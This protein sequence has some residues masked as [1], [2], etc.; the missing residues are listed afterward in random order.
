MVVRSRRSYAGKEGR[1][2]AG[3]DPEYCPD[4]ARFT[5]GDFWSA[6]GM[7]TIT[8]SSGYRLSII[9]HMKRRKEEKEDARYTDCRGYQVAIS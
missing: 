7:M 8:L 2:C 3:S 6:H 4:R 5:H 1:F 9:Y